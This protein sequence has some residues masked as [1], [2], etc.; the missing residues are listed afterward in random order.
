MILIKWLFYCKKLK[1]IET[2]YIQG[3]RILHYRIVFGQ[4]FA[5]F[6]LIFIYE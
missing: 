1:N 5:G 6:S 4:I 3:F 2:Q